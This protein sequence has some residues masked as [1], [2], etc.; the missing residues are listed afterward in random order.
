MTALAEAI[1]DPRPVDGIG[2]RSPVDGLARRSVG[3]VDV[4]AQSVSA[5]APSAAATTIPL[6]VAGA[7][8]GATFWA[9]AAASL[10]ALLVGT[11]VNQFTRRLA[12]TGSLY[13]FVSR[14]LG[15]TP[16]VVTGVALLLGYG[17]ISM[18]AL[19]GAGYYLAILVAR[20][21]PALTGSVLVP[22]LLIVAM[23][24]LC[25]VV[26]ARGIRISTRV[27]LLVECVSVA[28]ILILVVALLLRAGPS[29][30]WPRFALD[31][32]QPANLAVGA[33][34]ALTAFVGF[35]S[36]ST[37]GVEAKRPFASIP[38]SIIWTIVGSGLLYLVATYTQ[39]VGF[40]AL[41][42]DLM[43]SSSPVNDLAAAY[44]LDA[45]GLL[46]DV[47]VAASFLACAIASSTALV[48]VLFSMGREG[49]APER[50][51]RTHR[52]YRTPFDAA[53]FAMASITA[54]LLAVILLAGSVWRAMELLLIGAAGGYITAYGLVCVA[55]P[56]FLWRIGE[57]TVWP[58]IRAAVAV[59]LLSGVLVTYLA[60]ESTTDRVAGV[61]VFL[62][63][64]AIGILICGAR[65]VRKPGIRSALGVYDV[66]VGADVLGGPRA[67]DGSVPISALTA[68]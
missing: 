10:L 53:V 54:G 22:A 30:E 17:F 55:A 51:G 67:P 35:E 65:L 26:L 25:L 5:V 24:G 31:G 33:A 9:I 43:G 18:F 48:R 59:I 42:R 23:A 29:V 7:A 6:I 44:G 68:P 27:T 47:S 19:G 12:S 16:A 41:G 63:T 62:A 8:G 45:V 34:L 46:L 15:T 32:V 57:L 37:L 60:V 13:T 64:M 58:V 61:W 1:S 28:I 50:F 38:R 14:G 2:T 20:F 49:L 52:R 39:I 66:P 3:F 4:L 40:T 36:S 56:V 11:T 21:Q